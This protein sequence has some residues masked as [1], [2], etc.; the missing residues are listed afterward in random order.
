MEKPTLVIGGSGFVGQTLQDLVADADRADE[1]MFSYCSNAGAMRQGVQTLRLDLDDAGSATTAGGFDRAIWVAGNSD[2]GLGW[3][4]PR[5]DWELS[6]G[7][8]LN[9]LEHFQGDLTMLSSQATYFGLD[10]K[11]PESVDH[12]PAMPYGFAKLAAEKYADWAVQAERLRSLRVCRLMYAFGIHEKERRLL[13]RCIRA[14]RDGGTVT[15]AGGGKSFLNPVPA[16][17][18][19]DVL[20]R[21]NDEAPAR[22]TGSV[23]RFNV[24]HPDEWTVR[25]VVEFLGT[26]GPFD[27]EVIEGG[28]P[29]PVTFRGDVTKLTSLLEGWGVR[30]PDVETS[31]A[32]Y[33]DQVLQGDQA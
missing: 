16:T 3:N 14:S 19:A 26:L 7:T 31:L 13:Q 11:I 1:F 9:L 22:T 24:N 5:A 17:F 25:G 6:V 21:L 15:I 29:W 18:L 2:H 12:A 33:R 27:Y 30:F 20:V 32:S 23:D 10:G 28:E 8:L 4:D